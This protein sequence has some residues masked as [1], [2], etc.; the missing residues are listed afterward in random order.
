MRRNSFNNKGSLTVEACICFPVFLCFFMLLLFFVKL[1]CINL[2]LDMAVNETAKQIAASAYPVSFINE[3]EDDII[4]KY[5]TQS[6]PTVREEVEKLPEYAGIGDESDVY[7][8]ILTGNLQQP[9]LEGMI[10]R[11]ATDY[12]DGIIG[13][14]IGEASDDYWSYKT[15]AKYSIAKMLMDDF[16]PNGLI[17]EQRLRFRLV[18]FPQGEE[19]YAA[20]SSQYSELGFNRDGAIDITKDDVVVQ[21][22][23][24]FDIPIPLYG[25]KD[26]RMVHTAIEK[27]WL[28]GGCGVITSTQEGLELS[29]LQPK[30][31]YVTRTGEKYHLGNCRY[32]H[33][34]KIPMEL[35]EAKQ[36]YEPCKVCKPPVN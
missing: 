16:I 35:E 19:E 29:D 8:D 6:I 26:I 1:A 25:R 5:G 36:K 28:K 12:K 7:T 11:I 32:L 31:V 2:T 3:L 13:Y 18:E 15:G 20:R 4:N 10:G 14:L 23:Y 27:A 9:D 21:V 34:S 30:I 33:K 22:E 17:E 24:R